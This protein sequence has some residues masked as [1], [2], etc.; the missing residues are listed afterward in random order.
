LH[1]L[2]DSITLDEL[3]L[4]YRACGNETSIQ[5]KM[6]AASQGADVDFDDDWYDPTPVQAAGASEISQI[7]IGL[8]YEAN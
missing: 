7:P 2:E 5:M 4:L 8:G 3:F 1:E 6:L